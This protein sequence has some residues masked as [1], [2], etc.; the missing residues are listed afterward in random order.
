MNNETK[1]DQQQQSKAAPPQAKKT[2]P[3]KKTGSVRCIRTGRSLLGRGYVTSLIN[4]G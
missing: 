2:A 3:Q 4:H 1:Q